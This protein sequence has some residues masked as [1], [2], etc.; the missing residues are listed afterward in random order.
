M[1]KNRAKNYCYDNSLCTCTRT[2]ENWH[3]RSNRENVFPKTKYIFWLF[4]ILERCSAVASNTWLK[5]MNKFRKKLFVGPRGFFKQCAQHTYTAY[6]FVFFFCLIILL[7]HSSVPTLMWACVRSS[8]DTGIARAQ[9]WKWR[10]R[11][12]TGERRYRTEAIRM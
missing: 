1:Q 6:C 9:D 2:H 8:F 10:L 7:I 11:P 5:F 3:T 12:Y 4:S